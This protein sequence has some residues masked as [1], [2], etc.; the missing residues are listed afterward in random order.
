MTE[1]LI[2]KEKQNHLESAAYKLAL[3]GD[4]SDQN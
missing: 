4:R 1:T 3:L 2:A